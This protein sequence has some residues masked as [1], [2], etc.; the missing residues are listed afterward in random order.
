MY[1]DDV[2]LFKF[3]HPFDA[4]ATC[5]ALNKNLKFTAE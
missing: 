5:S 1:A 4:F 3:F 2:I